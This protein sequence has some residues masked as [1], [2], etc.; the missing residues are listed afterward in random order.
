MSDV[1]KDKR[2]S[3]STIIREGFTKWREWVPRPGKVVV[4]FRRRVEPR[5]RRSNRSLGT[6]RSSTS[7]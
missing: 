6:H 2:R 7:V 4:E 5:K 3:K 1:T